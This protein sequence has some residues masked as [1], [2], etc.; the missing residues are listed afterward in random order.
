MAVFVSNERKA[1]TGNSPPK[2]KNVTFPRF[3]SLSIEI[4]EEKN[5]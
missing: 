5:R 4:I 1:V 2:L 3:Q